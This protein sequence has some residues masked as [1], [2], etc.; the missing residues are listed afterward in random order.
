MSTQVQN[1]E[2][3]ANREY[4]FGFVT[5]IEADSLPPGLNEA[6]CHPAAR[7]ILGDHPMPPSYRPV[8]EY[9]ALID[10]VVIRTIKEHGIVLTTFGREAA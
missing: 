8:D 5:D 4:K 7:P 3:L 1:L 9:R 6:Y 10:P 2:E